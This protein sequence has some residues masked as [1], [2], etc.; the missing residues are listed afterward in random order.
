MNIIEKSLWLDE[1]W[2]QAMINFFNNGHY[3]LIIREALLVLSHFYIYILFFSMIAY[4]AAPGGE[5][6]FYIS[7]TPTNPIRNR[8]GESGCIP[9]Y[10]NIPNGNQPVS[11]SLSSYSF[12]EEAV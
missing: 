9:D 3:K 5:E 2:F 4:I 7:T 10:I 8:A 11:D 6:S 1:K 12:Q